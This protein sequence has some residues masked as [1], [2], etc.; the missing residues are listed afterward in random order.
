MSHRP[1]L[2]MLGGFAGCGK[3]TLA[4]KY[5][6]ETA[7]ALSIEG[8]EIITKL[9]KWREN[10]KEAIASKL[11]LTSA[12]AETHLQDG[13]DVILPFLLG[14]TESAIHYEDIA[15][16]AGADFIEITLSVEKPDALQRLLKR[17]TWGEA[18]LPPL[19]QADI[20]K[21]ERLYDSMVEAIKSRPNMIHVESKENDI[22]STYR[23]F[24]ASIA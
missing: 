12:M 13:H 15:R 23:D 18:G 22:E 7:L 14:D 10:V 19:T 1:K 21:I 16:A 6:S 24:I 11:S 5:V 20:P 3:T 9:G 17:G 2:I 4:N 8:D